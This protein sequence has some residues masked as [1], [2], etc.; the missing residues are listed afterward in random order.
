M[1]EWRMLEIWSLLKIELRVKCRCVGDGS[2]FLPAFWLAQGCPT[3]RAADW[4]DS[5]RLTSI[6]LASSFFCCRSESHTAHQRLAPT[7]SSA[8]VD[9]QKQ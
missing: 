7:V 5:S 6:F 8:I 1:S 9:M 3:K 2:A 4:W